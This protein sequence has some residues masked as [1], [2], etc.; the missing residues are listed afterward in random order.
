[1]IYRFST[2]PIKITETF[3]S[4]GQTNS[5][6]CK[7][8]K[9]GHISHLW[10]KLTQFSWKKNELLLH[11]NKYSKERAVVWWNDKISLS[12]NPCSVTYNYLTLSIASGEGKEMMDAYSLRRH[13]R[14]PG[15]NSSLPSPC[16]SLPQLSTMILRST[17]LNKSIKWHCAIRLGRE[18]R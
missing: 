8:L 5:K 13:L 14:R 7:A 15:Y 12:S 9:I 2:I 18:L 10:S 16:S 1:M 3:N 11:F 6:I 17:V 4:N